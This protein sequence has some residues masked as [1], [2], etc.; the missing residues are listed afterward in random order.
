MFAHTCSSKRQKDTMLSKFLKKLFPIFDSLSCNISCVMTYNYKPVKVRQFTHSM[1]NRL[2][3]HLGN[4][5]LVDIAP[6]ERCWFG[7]N[8]SISQNISNLLLLPHI[9]LISRLPRDRLSAGW[10]SCQE[11]ALKWQLALRKAGITFSYWWSHVQ[12]YNSQQF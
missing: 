7:F 1:N 9:L 2:V 8:S 11:A 12:V 10:K 6:L 5:C 4:S 3:S